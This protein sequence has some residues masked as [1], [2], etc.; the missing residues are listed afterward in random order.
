M[1]MPPAGLLRDMKVS[2]IK[3][4]VLGELNIYPNHVLKLDVAA[5]TPN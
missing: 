2:L 4:P 5:F 3:G 1:Q